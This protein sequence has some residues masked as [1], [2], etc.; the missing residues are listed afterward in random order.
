MGNKLLKLPA[1]I[2]TFETIRTEGYIYVDKTRYFVDLIDTGKV[3]FLSR[4]RRFGKL[5]NLID[6]SMKEEYGDSEKI[7]IAFNS[8]LAVIPY[9]DFTKAA[10]ENVIIN[11]YKFPAQ[12]WL[13]R[14]TILAFLRGCGVVLAA[15]MHTNLGRADLVIA[16][17]GKTYVIEIKVAY[18]GESAKEKAKEALQQI[19]DKN[20]AKPYPDATCLGIAIDDSVRQIA[21]ICKK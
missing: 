18:A 14:S 13:Y 5:N 20:Y 3:Y 12:E 1:G 2:Q 6:I 10:Q 7:M 8:L 4:P 21:E 15:E 11:G 9:G 17:R 19:M 16:H